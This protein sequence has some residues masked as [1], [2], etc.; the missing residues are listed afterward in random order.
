MNVP[1]IKGTHTAMKSAMLAAEA[2]YAAISADRS[3]DVLD[4]YPT[5]LHKSWSSRS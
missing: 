5:A 3:G 4:A 2:A 1:R